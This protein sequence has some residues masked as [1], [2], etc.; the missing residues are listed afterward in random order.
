M[1][2]FY[3]TPVWLFFIALAIPLSVVAI[4]SRKIARQIEVSSDFTP[5]TISKGPLN[6]NSDGSKSQTFTIQQLSSM[7]GQVKVPFGPVTLCA[8]AREWAANAVLM[9][10]ILLFVG[11]M[12]LFH[13]PNASTFQSDKHEEDAAV[14]AVD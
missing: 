6:N 13:F 4:A 11:L 8:N 7:Y 3:Q 10:L 12:G 5:K 9:G 1:T 2:L 14:Q